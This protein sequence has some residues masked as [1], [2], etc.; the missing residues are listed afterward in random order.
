MPEPRPRDPPH[1]VP[2]LRIGGGITF[3]HTPERKIFL[4]NPPA[5]VA[6]VE[7][8]GFCIVG[9]VAENVGLAE[10]GTLC[11][12]KSIQAEENG[13]QSTIILPLERI[14]VEDIAKEQVGEDTFLTSCWKNIEETLVSEEIWLSADF[15]EER[16]D[17]ERLLT[18][19]T[20]LVDAH[21]EK[22]EA[23]VGASP[24]LREIARAAREAR[25]VLA[26]LER[27]EREIFGALIDHA[28]DVVGLMCLGIIG[29]DMDILF[30]LL[31]LL[32]LQDHQERFRNIHSLLRMLIANKDQVFEPEFST[33]QE[34][35]EM[36]IKRM[37]TPDLKFP[38]Q[39]IITSN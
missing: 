22:Y 4:T 37:A 23:T 34:Y 39:K 17:M 1:R 9:F 33:I 36:C 31:Y 8:S 6:A 7:E 35:L 10:T 14:L 16:K 18:L 25:E 3:P 11:R 38:L 21:V 32:C 19:F 12:L 26:L 27:A 24:F 13:T 20:Q 5:L 28:C 2:I 15:R 30:Q 29:I